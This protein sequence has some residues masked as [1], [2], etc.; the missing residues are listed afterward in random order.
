MKI[1]PAAKEHVKF[2][3]G[4]VTALKQRIVHGLD[5]DQG[6]RNYAAE[7]NGSGQPKAACTREPRDDR[8]RAPDQREARLKDSGPPVHRG[9]KARCEVVARLERRRMLHERN[10]ERRPKEDSA[11]EDCEHFS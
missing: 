9:E 8:S 5:D 7:E 11:T 6:E 10:V 4:N 2:D 1:T 3:R